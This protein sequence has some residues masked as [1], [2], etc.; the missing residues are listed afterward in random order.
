[1]DVVVGLGRSQ[2]IGEVEDVALAHD[3]DGVLGGNEEFPGEDKEDVLHALGPLL[4]G[5]A[6]ADLQP[7][8]SLDEVVEVLVVQGLEEGELGQEVLLQRGVRHS[9]KGLRGRHAEIALSGDVE[10]VAGR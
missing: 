4:D 1:M 10:E 7:Y 8:Q 9:Q 6:V 2:Q 3:A 5:F